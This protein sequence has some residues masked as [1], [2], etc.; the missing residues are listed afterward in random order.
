MPTVDDAY[1]QLWKAI[2]ASLDPPTDA[3]LYKAW[4]D[5]YATWGSPVDAEFTTDAGVP[6]QV[7]ANAIVEWHDD[8][9]HVLGQST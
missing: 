6:T 2:N 8:G 4:V 3:G 9:A 5:N 1:A 7:F